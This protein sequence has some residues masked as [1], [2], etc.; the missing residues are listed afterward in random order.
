VNN[1]LYCNGGIG[2][3]ELQVVDA[4]GY[5]DCVIG[6]NIIYMTD[7]FTRVSVPADAEL[8]YDNNLFY[9]IVES[10]PIDANHD[11][12]A[13][14]I[15]GNPLLLNPLINFR[16]IFG[17]PAI[18]AASA[19]YAPATDYI[20][21]ARPQDG[22]DDIGAYEY[23]TPIIP[24]SSPAFPMAGMLPLVF[25]AM[26][27]LLILKMVEEGKPNIKVLILIAILIYLALAFLPNIQQSITNL[28]GG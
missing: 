3:Y 17:S 21:T 4:S 1:T 20:G 7:P 19:T 6:N 9:N 10:Y 12:G 14:A 8:V 11:Y 26:V 18:D 16:L 25:I 2:S 27:I 24:P 15:Y 28:I 23:I 5:L 22:V 13:N